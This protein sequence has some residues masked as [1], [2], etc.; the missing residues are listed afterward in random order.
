MKPISD[1]R[2]CGD[3]CTYLR[4]RLHVLAWRMQCTA[5]TDAVHCRS[6]CSALRLKWV[7]LAPK[8]SVLFWTRKGRRDTPH[9]GL[10]SPLIYLLNLFAVNSSS[11]MLHQ[12]KLNSGTN[13]FLSISSNSFFIRLSSSFCG[14][15]TPRQ[16]LI[17]IKSVS[18]SGELTYSSYDAYVL[19]N[20]SLYI[21]LQM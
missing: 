6:G 19:P 8:S 7:K 2:T 16:S 5:R 4:E 15:R 10:C 20:G 14:V 17:Q 13:P 21:T 1:A 18:R 12:S 9:T 3:G 11:M